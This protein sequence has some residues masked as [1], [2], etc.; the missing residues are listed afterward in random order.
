MSGNDAIVSLPGQ[1]VSWLSQQESLEGINFMTEFPSTPKATPLKRAIVAV[2]MESVVIS[3][4]YVENGEGIL[5]RSEYCRLASID[6]RLG[7]HVPYSSGGDRCHSV[8]TRIADCMSFDSDLNIISSECEAVQSDRDTDAFVMK[9]II[10][11]EAQFCQADSTGE[12]FTSFLPKT[13]FCAQHLNNQT[14]HVTQQDKDLWNEPFVVGAYFGN[15]ETQRTLNLGFTPRAVIVAGSEAPIIGLEP[16]SI[17]A[18]FFGV[19]ATGYSTQGIEL[20]SNGFR[21][22]QGDNYIVSSSLPRLNTD[23]YDYF[24]I[25]FK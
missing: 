24:Y 18:C 2:G 1:I 4:Y 5:E 14:I 23:G 6:L 8:F 9:A 16:Y 7:I 25:A 3:D 19:A 17:H 20:H 12:N 10:K 15:N 21:V 13:F 11:L 22:F